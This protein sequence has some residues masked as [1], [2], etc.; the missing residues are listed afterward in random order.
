M[1]ATQER[2]TLY[3]NYRKDSHCCYA[4]C[5]PASNL[6]GKQL[7][8]PDGAAVGIRMTIIGHN[9]RNNAWSID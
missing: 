6:P 8:A 1:P 7:P 4:P 2:L 3:A 5:E 9:G